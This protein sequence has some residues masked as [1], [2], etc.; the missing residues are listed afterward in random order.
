M[1]E[2]RAHPH[3]LQVRVEQLAQRLQLAPL[4]RIRGGLEARI[5]GLVRVCSGVRPTGVAM[6]TTDR[7]PG[8]L[9]LEA[10]GQQLL[11][12]PPQHSGAA[13]Q[14]C[15]TGSP[16]PCASVNSST[17]RSSHAP[18][19]TNVPSTA[20]TSGRATT[21]R[22]YRRPA[23]LLVLTAALP[24]AACSLAITCARRSL[25]MHVRV[26]RVEQHG[27]TSTSSHDVRAQTSGRSRTCLARNSGSSSVCFDR[28]QPSTR[29]PE[30]AC[31]E[32]GLRSRSACRSPCPTRPTSRSRPVHP[33]NRGGT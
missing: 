14:L 27:T 13:Q 21:S 23:W 31:R 5:N 11:V 32:S 3:Q 12:R 33:G 24:T 1:N 16:S 17:C 18:T 15:A 6:I 8:G 10:G 20:G 19:E 30:V 22:A 9:A 4:D 29:R 28:H 7:L 2:R 26:S 25:P